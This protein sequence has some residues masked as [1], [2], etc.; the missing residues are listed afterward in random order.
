MPD[1]EY[2][3]HDSAILLRDPASLERSIEVAHERRDN[4]GDERLKVQSRPFPAR[5][6]R[7]GDARSGSC[8]PPADREGD[9][10]V[11]PPRAGT[12]FPASHQQPPQV[13]ALTSGRRASSY[14]T[15]AS[16]KKTRSAADA[17]SNGSLPERRVRTVTVPPQVEFVKR[18]KWR[19][20][21]SCDVMRI[22]GGCAVGK[23]S[24][25]STSFRAPQSC[26]REIGLNRGGGPLLALF[27]R[28][29]A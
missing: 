11:T 13:A 9:T 8:R 28:A 21:A 7:R 24:E 29:S 16:V 6:N 1:H 22:T 18:P 5:T 2:G 19:L 14:K 15:R 17:L 26:C 23:P 3:T 10:P 12:G 20:L 25:R 27:E 4:L